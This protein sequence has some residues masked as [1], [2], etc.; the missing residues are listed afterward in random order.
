VIAIVAAP[1]L[2]PVEY[3]TRPG[4]VRTVSLGGGRD[5]LVMNGATKVRLT[6]LARRTVELESGQVLV[7]LLEPGASKVAV[8]SGDLKL[9]DFGTIFE[10]AR[11]GRETRVKV[12]EGAV[13]ADPA[14]ARLKLDAGEGLQTVDGAARLRAMP[15]NTA[16]VGA[17][18]RGQLTYVDER[19]PHVVADLRRSTGLDISISE[20]MRARRFTGT[21]SVAEVRRDPRSLGPLLGVSLQPSGK[22]WKLQERA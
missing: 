11:D 7:R 12:S 21:L 17:F 3:E 9:V 15:A 10:V 18:E 20:A 6:G 2:M 16:S 5:Q 1:Q 19:L 22:G 13:V 8:L 4:E 14:G